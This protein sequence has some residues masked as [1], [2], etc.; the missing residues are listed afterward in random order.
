MSSRNRGCSKIL[1]SLPFRAIWGQILKN[2][3]FDFLIWK[4]KMRFFASLR[5]TNKVVLFLI[6]TIQSFPFILRPKAER[7]LFWFFDLKRK[8]GILR[9]CSEWHADFWNSLSRKWK[10]LKDSCKFTFPCHPE[11][12]EGSH[13]LMFFEN[14]E[15]PRFAQNDTVGSF[16]AILKL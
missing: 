3:F 12:S 15:I 1:V 5:M 2:L 6:L 10:L 13:F 16:P 14:K 7:S 4:Q 9:W 8:E 11:R